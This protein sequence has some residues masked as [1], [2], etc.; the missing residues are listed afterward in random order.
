MMIVRMMM[1]MLVLVLVL[2]C[3]L[4]CGRN[5]SCHRNVHTLACPTTYKIDCMSDNPTCKEGLQ[6]LPYGLHAAWKCDYKRASNCPCHRSRQ[7]SH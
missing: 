7:R 3:T 4:A 6:I 5:I 2:P 1:M